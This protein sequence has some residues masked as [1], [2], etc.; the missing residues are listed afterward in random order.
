[1]ADWRTAIRR[2]Y[3][4]LVDQL[5]RNNFNGV[6]DRLY[7][8][9]VLSPHNHEKFLS[10]TGDSPTLVEDKLRA[11]LNLLEANLTGGIL[12]IFQKALLDVELTEIA[13]LIEEDLS[14]PEVC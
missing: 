1:M 8:Q 12:R 6:L 10:S 3:H 9:G 5:K 4:L 2:R 13:Q 14:Q 7:A 11:F